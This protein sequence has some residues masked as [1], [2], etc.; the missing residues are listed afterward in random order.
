MFKKDTQNSV[1]KRYD[2]SCPIDFTLCQAF[3]L[4]VNE[5]CTHK[6]ANYF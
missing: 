2:R 6:V 4:R 1:D 5:M 3:V